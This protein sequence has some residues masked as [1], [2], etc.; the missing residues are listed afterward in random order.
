MDFNKGVLKALGEFPD[1]PD[2]AFEVTASEDQD[3]Y[4]RQTVEY[5]VEAGE[6]IKAYLLIPKR[7]KATN[8]AILAA[9]QHAG[10]YH[11]GKSEVV[12]MAG[13]PMYAY[14][15][16][17]V[18]RGYVVLA[19]DHLA[20][21]ERIDPF[22]D[23]EKGA[24]ERYEF[25]RRIAGGSCLQTKYL[26]DL[27]VAVDVL[28]ALPGVD[29]DR[30]GVVGH[31]LG[32]Q[33]ATWLMWYDKRI[34]AAVSSCGIG[35]IDT[36]FRDHILHN[37]ALY[38]PGFSKCGDISDLVRHI[39]PRP[40]FMTNGLHDTQLFPVDGVK[41]IAEK[42]R[43]RYAELGAAQNFRSIIFDGGHMFG[44]NEKQEVY[45]WLDDMLANR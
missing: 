9:H 2:P 31:S 41:T 4:T 36:I 32:G 12:G 14:G 6:R 33:E 16:D 42:A 10:Q 24:C 22:F 44:D 20:F 21:E 17:L 45:A 1:K 25:V 27:S 13:D 15:V 38:V 11:L 37:Y 26:H 35:Q 30:I 5:N 34:A 23:E 28:E 8:P 29:Q 7:L 43:E 39:A 40:F 3:T 19:P 18:K